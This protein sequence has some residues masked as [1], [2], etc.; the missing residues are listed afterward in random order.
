[1]LGEAMEGTSA[2]RELEI[3]HDGPNSCV[4][5][6]G[7]QVLLRFSGLSS[8]AQIRA[9]TTGAIGHQWHEEEVGRWMFL[10]GRAPGASIEKA[11]RKGL[12]ARPSGW[13]LFFN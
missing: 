2:V 3:R 12:W 7:A 5:P 13:I 10:A 9:K 8:G 1:M 4:V 6:S 11:G